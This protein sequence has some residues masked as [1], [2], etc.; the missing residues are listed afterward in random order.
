MHWL[1]KYT[2]KESTIHNMLHFAH[3]LY[4]SSSDMLVGTIYVGMVV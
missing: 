1:T 3:Y 2:N 4:I